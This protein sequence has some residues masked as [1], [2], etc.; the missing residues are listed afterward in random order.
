[1]HMRPGRVTPVSHLGDLLAGHHTIPGAHEVV[2]DVPVDVDGAVVAEQVD[3]QPEAGG[4]PST[5]DGSR[6]GGVKRRA[7]GRGDV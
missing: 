5:L 6:D 2:V 1:M 3:S 7:D 4:R